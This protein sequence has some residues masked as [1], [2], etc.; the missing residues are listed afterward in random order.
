MRRRGSTGSEGRWRAFEDLRGR[1]LASVVLG[2]AAR[3]EG[4]WEGRWSGEEACCQTCWQCWRARAWAAA[5]L[6]GRCRR[7]VSQTLVRR[8]R[9]QPGRVYGR[10]P[11][12]LFPG[13][14]CAA[15]M[16]AVTSRRRQRNSSSW[17][18]FAGSANRAALVQPGAAWCSSPAG[19]AWCKR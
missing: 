5:V 8:V 14:H 12:F 7:S 1:G 9:W 10:F 4:L 15:R 13:L 6:C 18:Q 16:T 2:R 11:F 3:A 17:L 19:R